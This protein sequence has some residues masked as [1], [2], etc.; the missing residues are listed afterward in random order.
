MHRDLILA[1]DVEKQ[2]DVIN[3]VKSTI[4]EKSQLGILKIKNQ[5]LKRNMKQIVKDFGAIARKGEEREKEKLSIRNTLGTLSKHLSILKTR[6]KSYL[7]EKKV[8]VKYYH[9]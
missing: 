8:T 9:P 3:C 2:M 5:E 1:N 4:E 6:K 7:K